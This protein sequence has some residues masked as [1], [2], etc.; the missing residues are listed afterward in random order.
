[1]VNMTEAEAACPAV[2]HI[3]AGAHHAVDKIAGAANHAAESVDE[4]YTQWK[5]AQSRIT[6]NCLTHIRDNPMAT[7]GIALGAGL[8]V[9]WLL[10]RR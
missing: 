5:D 3:A 7:V 1:M 8:L 9:G 6:K 2:D 10:K 4:K